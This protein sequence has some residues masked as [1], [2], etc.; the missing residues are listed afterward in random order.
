VTLDFHRQSNQV[1]L[2]NLAETDFAWFAQV[3]RQENNV[4][5]DLA[6]SSF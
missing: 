1:S 6:Q 5:L 2:G 4:E 3:A